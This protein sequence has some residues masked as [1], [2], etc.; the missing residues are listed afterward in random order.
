MKK[1]TIA[2]AAVLAL[3]SAAPA[4]ADTET[5]DSP[6]VSS[7]FAGFTFLGLSGSAGISMLAFTFVGLGVSVAGDS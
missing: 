3:A 6:F 2:A 1:F 5:S 4:I 7:Q